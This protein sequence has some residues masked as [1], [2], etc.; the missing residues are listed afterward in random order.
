ML[1]LSGFA[2]YRST[3]AIGLLEFSA[4]LTSSYN[5]HYF[6]SFAISLLKTNINKYFFTMAGDTPM[7]DATTT[8]QVHATDATEDD[9]DEFEQEM[10]EAGMLLILERSLFLFSF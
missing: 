10:I 3:R 4:I 7:P 5:N 1:K 8:T 6:I 9:Y 2:K